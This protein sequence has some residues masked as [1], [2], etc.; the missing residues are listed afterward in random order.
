LSDQRRLEPGQVTSNGH[1]LFGM[2]KIPTD[3]NIRLRLDKV[4]PEALQPCVD[5]LIEAL[6][7]RD[8]LKVFERLGGPTLVALEGTEYFCSQKL[9][10]PQG[11]RRKRSNGK[12]EPDHAMLGDDRGSRPQPQ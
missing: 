6:R 4:S 9:S 1:T 12:T 5:Q 2:K 8:G 3:N 7:E 10:C 11:L